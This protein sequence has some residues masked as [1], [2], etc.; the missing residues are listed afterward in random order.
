MSKPAMAV[1]ILNFVD[2]VS[3]AAFSNNS[4][5]VKRFISEAEA[6][7]FSDVLKDQSFFDYVEELTEDVAQGGISCERDKRTMIAQAI[8]RLAFSAVY[9][10]EQCETKDPSH[11][12]ASAYALHNVCDKYDRYEFDNAIP[13]HKEQI[14]INSF[15]HHKNVV[16]V[17]LAYSYQA[18]RLDEYGPTDNTHI[19]KV[20]EWAQSKHPEAEIV[21]LLGTAKNNIC[22][23]KT[24]AGF[25]MVH[26]PHSFAEK[27]Q[28]GY[29]PPEAI[30]EVLARK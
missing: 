9:S 25:E 2:K 10:V 28:F 8:V 22:I 1:D 5:M 15:F 30:A 24:D 27:Y 26:L 18:E 3:A 6:T 7:I 14:Y 4:E 16:Y 29:P 12:L 13:V 19:N 20:G 23:V 21:Y 11:V 17:R